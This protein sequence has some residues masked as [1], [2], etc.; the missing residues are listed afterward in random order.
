MA[1]KVLFSSSTSV[2]QAKLTVEETTGPGVRAL[3]SI[4]LDG[5][6]QSEVIVDKKTGELLPAQPLELVQV[7]SMLTM[8]WIEGDAHGKR[9]TEAP[10]VL[11]IGVGG[12]SIGIVLS[13]AMPP[14]GNIHMIE[15]EPE[16]LQAAVDFFGLELV[17]GRCT[18]V[19]GDGIAH[20]KSHAAACQ[21]QPEEGYEVLMLDAFTSEG[22]CPSTQ[23]GSTLDDARA[24]LSSRGLLILNL[25]T[26]DESDPDYKVARRVLRSLCERFDCVYTLVCHTTMNLMALCHDGELI[27][28]D[29]WESR[30]RGL[31]DSS[32]AL[33]AACRGGGRDM[34]IDVAMARFNYVGGRDEPMGSDPAIGRY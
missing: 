20:L 4:S 13:A 11:L 26:G 19:A 2:T 17:E 22:L 23:Q 28:A 29:T 12:G 24:C 18:G 15:L 16:V 3:R 10:K 14:A 6:T 27:D 7:M 32:P 9:P 30:F 34:D 1:N 21:E 5:H 8:A 25:H 31:L 33:C